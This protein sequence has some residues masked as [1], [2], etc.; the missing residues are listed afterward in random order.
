MRKK[1][2]MTEGRE[3]TINFRKSAKKLSPFLSMLG[4]M[5]DSLMKE[6]FLSRIIW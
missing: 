6:G 1:L 3:S 4:L 2:T 5:D